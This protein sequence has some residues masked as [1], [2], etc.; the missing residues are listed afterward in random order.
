M[1]EKNYHVCCFTGH[2]NLPI[3]S[4]RAIY[5]RLGRAVRYAYDRGV[6]EFRVGGALGFDTLAALSVLDLRE[7]LPGLRL[8]LYLPC[9]DQDLGWSEQDRVIYADIF[10]RADEVIYISEQYFGGC[11][12]KRNRALVDGSDV[13]IAFCQKTNGGSYYTVTYARSHGLTV[14][15]L[16]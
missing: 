6:R 8:C 4:M 1:E 11:M 2:R 14:W 7:Q 16:G 10:D 15:N 3:D 9:K 12:Q 5:S 13:C